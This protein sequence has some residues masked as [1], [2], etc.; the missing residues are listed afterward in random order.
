MPYKE[1]N[2]YFLAQSP[3]IKTPEPVIDLKGNTRGQL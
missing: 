2:S 3:K 1:L